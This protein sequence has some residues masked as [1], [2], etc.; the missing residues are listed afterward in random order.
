MNSLVWNTFNNK[1]KLEPV[2]FNRNTYSNR[3]AQSKK[4]V[5]IN[6]GIRLLPYPVCYNYFTENTKFKEAIV[7]VAVA[8]I[9]MVLIK[10]VHLKIIEFQRIKEV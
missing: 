9:C 10:T 4:Q 2:S 7:I 5:T 6:N 8:I 3:C 1:R